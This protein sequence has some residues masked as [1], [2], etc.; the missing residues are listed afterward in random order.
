MKYTCEVIINLPKDKTVSLFLDPDHYSKWQ[1]GFISYTPADKTDKKINYDAIYRYEVMNGKKIID[2]EE[3]I[4]NNLLP[5]SIEGTYSTEDMG[6]S[7]KSI[8]I[9]VAEN[10]TKYISEV[11][12]YYFNGFIPKMMS[13]F[14]KRMFKKQSQKWMSQFKSFAE[15]GNY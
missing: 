9:K 10:Q 5:D 6:N 11:E 2:L 13:I 12:Y 1:D 14:M 3:R 7:M 4:L 15:S 8:F